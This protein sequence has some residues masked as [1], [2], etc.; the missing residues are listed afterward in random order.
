MARLTLGALQPRVDIATASHSVRKHCDDICSCGQR[1]RMG[2]EGRN[3]E[4][5]SPLPENTA[6]LE[7]CWMDLL[8][9]VGPRGVPY[10]LYDGDGGLLEEH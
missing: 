9:G 8:S 3:L 1:K 2:L 10:W 4:K 7:H 6:Q 5:C